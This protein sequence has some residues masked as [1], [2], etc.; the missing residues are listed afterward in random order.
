[1][2]KLFPQKDVS[3]AIA[4]LLVHLS[5]LLVPSAQRDR[6]REEWLGELHAAPANRATRRRALGAPRDAWSTRAMHAADRRAPA[7][8][9]SWS[10]WSTDIKY[11]WRQL[12]RRPGYT[13]AVIACLGVG[14]A[15]S[16]GTFSFLMSLLYGDLAGLSDRR[17]IARVYLSYDSA[18]SQERIAD[19][20]QVIAEPLSLSDLVV[21]R[22]VPSNAAISALSGEGPLRMTAAGL[23]GPSAWRAR[24]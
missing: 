14:L 3:D 9:S 20:R 5:A 7:G 18:T 24:S 4:R 6:W 21:L 2:A 8:Q 17:S 16:V 19:G 15:A 23:H 11:A 1:V 10:A 13:L 22:H 12:I